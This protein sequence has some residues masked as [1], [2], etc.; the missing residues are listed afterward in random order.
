M[1]T[2]GRGWVVGGGL[3]S[4]I[5]A[6]VGHAGQNTAA[7]GFQGR[8][9]GQ[10]GPVTSAGRDSQPSPERELSQGRGA[11]ALGGP[12]V[13]LVR[14]RGD[15]AWARLGPQTPPHRAPQGAAVRWLHGLCGVRLLRS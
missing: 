13:E 10:S 7:L 1:G 8:C 15:L 4:V 2:A 3:P 5:K 12:C 11:W 6:T 14:T 9:G